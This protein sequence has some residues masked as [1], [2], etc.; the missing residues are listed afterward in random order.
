MV[1]KYERWL[2][3]LLFLIFG[4]LLVVRSQYGLGLSDESCYLAAAK[5]LGGI[6]HFERSGTSY[7]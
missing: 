3:W 4:L 6:G 2:P 5:R 7:S 1:K